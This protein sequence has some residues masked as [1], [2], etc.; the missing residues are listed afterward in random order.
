MRQWL[1]N[2]VGVTIACSLTLLAS[3]VWAQ[4]Q[5]Q[6]WSA[7]VKRVSS[8]QALYLIHARRLLVDISD[9]KAGAIATDAMNISGDS[10]AIAKLNNSPAPA[11]N[12]M[13]YEWAVD[14]EATAAYSLAYSKAQTQANLKTVV[15]SMYV[16]TADQNAITK[17]YNTYRKAHS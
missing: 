2:A 8:E 10:G 14:M 13:V 17:W 4:P 11:L 3:P 6:S 1:R 15:A 9:S 12:K 16:C 7:W 5:K